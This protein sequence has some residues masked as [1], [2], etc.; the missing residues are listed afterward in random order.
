MKRYV[1]VLIVL[2]CS[3][4]LAAPLATATQLFERNGLA[5]DGYDPVAYFTE[6]KAV[7]GLPDFRADYHGST[8]QFMSAEHRAAFAADPEKFAPQYGGYCAYGTAKGYKAKIAPEAF[9]VVQGK[10][11]LNYSEAVRTRWL[12]DIPGYIQKADANWPE[13]Q[14]Q[15]RVRE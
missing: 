9:T 15:T 3:V 10:L 11:Y 1:Q 6:M 4:L 12:S 5:I 7:K 2:V 8:F 13:V 14:K